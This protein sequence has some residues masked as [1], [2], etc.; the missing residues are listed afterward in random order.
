MAFRQ[1]ITREIGLNGLR[2]A[3][4]IHFI[5]VPNDD[6]AQSTDVLLERSALSSADYRKPVVEQARIGEGNPALCRRYQR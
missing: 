6:C 5:R 3:A 1:S 2:D 4:A